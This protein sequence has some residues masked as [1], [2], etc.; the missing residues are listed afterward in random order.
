MVPQSLRSFKEYEARCA[1]K[2][3]IMMTHRVILAMV[4]NGEKNQCIIWRRLVRV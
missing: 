3:S 2:N 4:I 1:L